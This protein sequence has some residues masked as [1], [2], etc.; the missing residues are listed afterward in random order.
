MDSENLENRKLRE[1]AENIA[2]NK[3]YPI[4]DLSKDELIEALRV[5]QIELELQNNELRESHLKLDDLYNKYFD[6]YNFAPVGYFTLNKNGLITDVNLAGAV[7]LGVNKINLINHAFIRFIDHDYRNEFHHHLHKITEPGQKNKME[8]KLQK[9]DNNLFYA[10]LEIVNIPDT[11]GELLESKITVTN[12]NELKNKEKELKNYQDTLEE[13][14]KK[15]TDELAKSNSELANFAYIASH[16]LREPLRMITSFLQLLERR[17]KDQLDQDANDFINYAVDGAKRLNEMI[18]D[19]LEYSKLTNNELNCTQVN[20]EKVL[21]NA[22]INLVIPT[23]ENNA[24]I[25]HDQ[26]PIV[27]GDDRLLTMLFQ[28]LI[29]NALKYH[30]R[31]Q[32]KIHISSKK[33]KNQYVI[34]IKD[35]GIGIKQEHLKRI[36]TIFQ[37]LH[38]QDEYPGT[39]IGLAI[40]KK[41]VHQHGGEIWVESELEKGTTFYFTIPNQNNYN[42]F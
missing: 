11:S 13:K 18:I 12:I 39:G 20:L 27:R 1:K 37:R 25:T 32:P 8:I 34:N 30:G 28:N 6:L 9:Q 5:H 29:G 36:F 33:E 40:S 3:V 16:D 26:L 22:L 17:Y 24:I 42:S 41:I 2:R 7:L 21:D 23:E 35:N 38:G 10:Y 4:N 14:V 19:L 31:K 15:R